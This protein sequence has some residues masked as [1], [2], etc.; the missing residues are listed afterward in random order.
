MTS[1]NLKST[2]PPAE[3]QACRGPR[4]G[5][6]AA[7]GPREAC[8]G[9][10]IPSGLGKVPAD[11]DAAS[12]RGLAR[13]QGTTVGR[14]SCGNTGSRA[15]SDCGSTTMNSAAAGE[16]GA[17]PMAASAVQNHTPPSNDNSAACILETPQGSDG[18]VRPVP[19]SPD[20]SASKLTSTPTRH[21]PKRKAADHLS[22]GR[23]HVPHVEL[24]VS[25]GEM[26]GVMMEHT[27]NGDTEQDTKEARR[28]DL[29]E[30]PTALRSH[31][32]LRNDASK[33]GDFVLHARM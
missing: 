15:V 31:L 16:E 19:S 4:H 26:K 22:P 29:Q 33:T 30:P 23:V 7:Q 5:V 24:Q 6:A 13:N 2:H 14:E 17:R 1:F 21:M 11:A 28:G 32:D 9:G 18:E 20:A 8:T 12:A 10:V 25:R 3:P 27:Q